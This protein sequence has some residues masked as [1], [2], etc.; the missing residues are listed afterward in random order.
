M[1][2]ST[3]ALAGKTTICHFPLG[4]PDNWHTI[5]VSDNA[6]DSHVANHG[7]FVGSCSENCDAICDDGDFCTQDVVSDL[8]DCIC[9]PAPGP[10]VDCDDGNECTADSCSTTIGACMNDSGLEDGNVCDDGDPGTI[11]TV[12]TVGDCVLPPDTCPCAG[13]TH[14]SVTWDDSF[15]SEYCRI[16]GPSGG[17]L[18]Y[19][20]GSFIGGYIITVAADDNQGQ[21]ACTV[22]DVNTNP[23]QVTPIPITEEEF[24]ACNISI[25]MI[26]DNDGVTCPE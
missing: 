16:N 10:A 13:T 15:E 20:I 8:N 19:E 26:A 9:Q 12:C 24:I 2:G 25:R 23:P 22:W 6:V 14:G 21:S 4:N 17:I 3:G 18:D 7:D 1:F 11:G 5:T